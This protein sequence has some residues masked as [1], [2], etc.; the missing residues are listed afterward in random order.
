M[1]LQEYSGG[2]IY[3]RRNIYTKEA[4]GAYIVTGNGL[5][6]RYS[7]GDIL[8]IKKQLFVEDY[9]PAIWI[10]KGEPQI[11]R[12]ISNRLIS[13]NPRIPPIIIGA[14]CQLVGP[15]IGVLDP[16]WIMDEKL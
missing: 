7:N 11:R 1:S 9:D 13:L 5:E 16:D 4:Q 15:V 14:D 8:L 6:P 12:K 2:C 10:V 3:A